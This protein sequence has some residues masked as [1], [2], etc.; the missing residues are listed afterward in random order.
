MKKDKI[1]IIF[2]TQ[3][4]ATQFQRLHP[5]V[6]VVIGGVGM[7]ATAATITKLLLREVRPQR[8]VMAGIAGSYSLG[9]LPLNQVVEV[10]SEQIEEL[11]YRYRKE[12][13]VTSKWGLKEATSSTVSRS[14]SLH[15]RGAEI[16]NMEGVILF[17]MCEG[18]PIEVSE[19]RSISNRVGAPFEEWQIESSIE[20]L[21]A[22]LSRIYKSIK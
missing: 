11:P 22:E 18:L 6:D 12:Y 4:E 9:Q 15:H 17:A 14:N 13:S 3:M 7:A 8:V 19:I 2:P 21:T 16:E 10:V 20:A 5:E 1:T